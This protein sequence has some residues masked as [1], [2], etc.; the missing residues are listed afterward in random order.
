[1]YV[2]LN[3]LQHVL[4]STLHSFYVAD[5]HPMWYLPLSPTRFAVQD[6]EACGREVP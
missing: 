4:P 5:N 3:F 6:T 1:M 2:L